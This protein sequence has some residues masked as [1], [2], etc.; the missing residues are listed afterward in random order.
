LFH[1]NSILGL[2]SQAQVDSSL[3]PAQE[4]NPAPLVIMD[5]GQSV[6]MTTARGQSLIWMVTINDGI[7]FVVVISSNAEV[8]LMSQHVFLTLKITISSL[9]LASHVQEP[10]GDVVETHGSVMLPVAREGI[11]AF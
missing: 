10:S 6:P 2:D 4:E 11:H 5:T 9:T 3:P 1:I 8:S 7:H